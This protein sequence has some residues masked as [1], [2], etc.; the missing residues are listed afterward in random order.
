MLCNTSFLFLHIFTFVTVFVTSI[1]II[2]SLYTYLM[3]IIREMLQI[4]Y[5][6]LI[7]FSYL[8]TNII[9]ALRESIWVGFGQNP[10]PNH[11]GNEHWLGLIKKN[12]FL[13]INHSSLGWILSCPYFFNLIISDEPWYSFYKKLHNNSKK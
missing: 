2:E 13:G 12:G 9:R 8:W 7:E 11:E 10:N 3:N 4:N 1:L 5:Q 6:N